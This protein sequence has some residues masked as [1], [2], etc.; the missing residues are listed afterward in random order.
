MLRLKTLKT[1]SKTI[2][3]NART[4]ST[5]VSAL[6]VKVENP[7]QEIRLPDNGYILKPNEVY[8]AE[9]DNPGSTSYSEGNFV[10]ELTTLG[11]SCRIVEDE[12]LLSVQRPVRI[13]PDMGMFY[14]D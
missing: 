7:M 10:K 14:E 1:Y 5:E 2:R 13:Y 4:G 11:I 9:V 3:R 6:D 12:C 8:V